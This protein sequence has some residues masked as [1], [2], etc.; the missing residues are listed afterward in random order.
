MK[1]ALQIL[2]NVLVFML[3]SCSDNGNGYQNGDT[4]V[5]NF[6]G[7]WYGGNITLVMH[8]ATWN[9]ED[10]GSGTY[11]F[12]EN[13]ATLMQGADLF[14]TAVLSLNNSALTL[15]KVGVA[16]PFEMSREEKSDNGDVSWSIA[17][18]RDDSN[19]DDI[20][21]IFEM[22]EIAPID[23]HVWAFANEIGLRLAYVMTLQTDRGSKV[24]A[25]GEKIIEADTAGLDWKIYEFFEL[26]VDLDRWLKNNTGEIKQKL[27]QAF[28]LEKTDEGVDFIDLKDTKEE[29]V[30]WYASNGNLA[31][32]VLFNLYGRVGE[33]AV[34]FTMTLEARYDVII[35]IDSED[36]PE[37]AFN[38]VANAQNITVLNDAQVVASV[39]YA[40]N[41]VRLQHNEVNV[42]GDFVL[43]DVI[44]DVM[45]VKRNAM[46][47]NMVL[48]RETSKQSANFTG[49][50]ISYIL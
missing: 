14:G 18:L 35:P 24:I 41:S 36:I 45:G 30:D 10:F 32:F 6:I 46:V 7:T 38:L 20:V 34:G 28:S 4:P 37:S 50:H 5:N 47:G 13:T 15:H 33:F 29:F 48:W 25:S 17:D 1:K 19:L 49:V 27:I 3:V 22:R 9:A 12:N 21:R 43:K 39:L 26:E 40:E 44:E 16:E 8:A 42:R 2:I 23:E 31:G 11:T